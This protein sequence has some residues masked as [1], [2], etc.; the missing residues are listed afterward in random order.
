MLCVRRRL[1]KIVE[2]IHHTDMYDPSPPIPSS[3]MAQTWWRNQM[4]TFSASLAICAGNSPVPSEFPTQRP[5][6]RSFDIF[7]LRPYKRLSKKSWGWWFETPSRPLWHHYNVMA[8]AMYSYFMTFLNTVMLH[9]EMQYHE[10]NIFGFKFQWS[11]T[12]R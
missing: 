10:K 7:D 3:Q 2:L 5:V 6:T 4:G 11:V 9:F 1:W 12:I 8:L